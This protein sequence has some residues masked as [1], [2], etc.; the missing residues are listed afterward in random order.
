MDGPEHRKVDGWM[1]RLTSH[2]TYIC[3][4][5]H[6]YRYIYTGT[7]VFT[8]S[9]GSCTDTYAYIYKS[10]CVHTCSVDVSY[11]TPSFI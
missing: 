9:V 10:A 7:C 11:N 8:L 2:Y 5:V 3:T 6:P 1:V 4:S